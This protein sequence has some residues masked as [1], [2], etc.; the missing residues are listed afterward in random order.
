[1]YLFFEGFGYMNVAR[2]IMVLRK[3]VTDTMFSERRMVV[4]SMAWSVGVAAV[5]TLLL[6]KILSNSLQLD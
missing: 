3:S 5:M 4:K 1:M 6:R 2:Y